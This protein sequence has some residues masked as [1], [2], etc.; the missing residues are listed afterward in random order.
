DQQTTQFKP[1]EER[2]PILPPR[3]KFFDDYPDEVTN[4]STLGDDFDAFAAS[5]AWYGYAQD[6][7][8][9]PQLRR[10][11]RQLTTVIFQGYPARAQA[12][13][14]ERLEQEGWF[15]EE[16]WV[17]KDWFPQFPSQPDGPKRPVTVGGGRKWAEDA[18]ERA[19]QM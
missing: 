19:F 2:F 12:Y 4:D 17:I 16:G 14:G 3:A 7:L 11:P 13:L 1:P 15:D 5:R 9:N 18:Y 6:P 10:R 8:L